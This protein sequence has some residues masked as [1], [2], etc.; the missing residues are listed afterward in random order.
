MDTAVTL[1]SVDPAASTGAGVS[2][3]AV[4]D[5]LSAAM[6][7]LAA[8]FDANTGQDAAGVLFGRQYVDTGRDLLK[9]VTAGADAC[10]NTGYGIRVT[11]VNYSRAEAAS[12]ISGRSQALPPPPCPAPISPPAPPTPAGGGVAEPLLWSLVEFLVG[13]FWP[14]GDAAAMR[15]AAGAWRTCGGVLQQVTS[16]T[17]GSCCVIEEQQMPEGGLITSSVRDIG[18]L[19]SSVAGSC[20]ALA[21]ELDGFAA[22]VE[23]TQRAIRDLLDKLGS[24][25]GIVGT[26]FEFLK[27]HGEDELHEIADDIQTVLS[28]LKTEADAKAALVE[29]AKQNIDGW[30]LSLERFA[31][32]KFVDFFGEDAGHALSAHFN[33]F[34]DAREGDFRWAVGMA[35]AT[36]AL[37]PLRFIYDPEGATQTW[38]PLLDTAEALANPS[39]IPALVASDPEGVKDILNGLARTD[40]FDPNRPALSLEENA[41]DILSLGIPGVGEAG[42]ASKAARAAEVADEA[43]GLARVAGGVTRATSALGDVSEQAAGVTSKLDDIAQKPVLP[44]APT[45]GRPVSPT[46][47]VEP[48]S[49]PVAK[50]PSAEST[51][52]RSPSAG[53]TPTVTTPA[54]PVAPPPRLPVN[55]PAEAAAPTLPAP[56]SGIP[57]G[58]PHSAGPTPASAPNIPPASTPHAPPPHGPH[59]PAPPAGAHPA[60]P[61]EHHGAGDRNDGTGGGAEAGMTDGHAETPPID[62]RSPEFDPTLLRGMAADDVRASIPDDWIV[63]PAKRGDGDTYEDPVH[64]GRQ[65]RIMDGYPPGSRPDDINLGP[66]VVVSQN[67]Q[68]LKIPLEGNPTLKGMR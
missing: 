35:Q 12:D 24:I 54:A 29:A 59:P 60:E 42:A 32:R 45:G 7:T 37:N 39:T 3:G 50:Q 40:E 48:S 6:A 4:G 38:K 58:T 17:S 66:Y 56:A 55:A 16:E 11:A 53:E 51:A 9:A 10:R 13:D 31:D 49:P 30:A 18:T 28:H 62:V 36:E 8:R 26:F 68:K 61:G 67:G 41:L 25:G 34:V 23:Q 21:D 65:I 2:V 20:T 27:G 63:R 15:T 22:D 19:L 5:G 14:N 52:P 1:L 64:R 57:A 47:P 33:D 43:A 44:E 46:Q